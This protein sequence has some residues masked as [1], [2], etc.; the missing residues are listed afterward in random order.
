MAH[1]MQSLTDI[2][3][4]VEKRAAIIGATGRI[5][6]TYGK[7]DDWARPHIEVDSRG[8]HYVVVERGQEVERFT[9]DNL[10]E[11]LYRVFKNVAWALASVYELNHRIDGQDCRRQLLGKQ[12]ELL[13]QLSPAW[14]ELQSEEHA[15]ILQE[16]PFDDFSLTRALYTKALRDKGQ[17]AD[18]AWRAACEKYPLPTNPA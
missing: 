9:T 3:R 10:D 2:Q 11:L 12:I 4:E 6:P 16:H 18:A 8:F 15:L 13:G 1:G 7:T 5:L 14:A 17:S